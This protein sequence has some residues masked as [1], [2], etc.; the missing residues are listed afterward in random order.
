MFLSVFDAVW[1]CLVSIRYRILAGGIALWISRGSLPQTRS[2]KKLQIF[3]EKMWNVKQFTD[4]RQ[5]MFLTFWRP[6]VQCHIFDKWKSKNDHCPAWFFTN[7]VLLDVDVST[8]QLK[9]CFFLHIDQISISRNVFC[10]HPPV[11]NVFWIIF[12]SRFLCWRVC[13]KTC[14]RFGGFMLCLFPGIFSIV[15]VVFG[16]LYYN[17]CCL[18]LFSFLCVV[19]N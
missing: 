15:L 5:N 16:F 11:E 4:K 14:Y 12:F 7:L 10:A 13:N 9:P 6:L 2:L 1:F 8:K 17:A 19:L 18:A 3:L